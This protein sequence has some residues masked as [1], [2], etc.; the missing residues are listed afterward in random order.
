MVTT[1]PLSL[2]TTDRLRDASFSSYLNSPEKSIM[3]KLAEDPNSLFLGRK[4][5][6]EGEI[7]VFG[8]EKYFNGLMGEENQ[9][10]SNNVRTKTQH[11]KNAPIDIS[12]S[13]PKIQPRT[14]SVHSESSWNSQSGL[15]QS[16][17]RNPS[18]RKGKKRNGK[19]FI[20]ILGCSCS[21]NGKNSVVI[22]E[23]GEETNSK[24]SLSCGGFQ[25]KMG[26]QERTKTGSDPVDLARIKQ[27]GLNP[28]VMEEIHC[29]K[30]DEMGNGLSRED[31]FSFP[32]LNSTPG[33]NPNPMNFQENQ[34]GKRWHNS[35]EV[36]G[37]SVLD[38]RNKNFL[39]LEGNPIMWG[40]ETDSRAEEFEIP[41]SSDAMYNDN[42]SD[43]S[44][45]LFEIESFANSGN[46]F[47]ERNGSDEM[48]SN[49]TH[50]TCYAPSEVSIEWSV[51]TASAAGFSS[52]IS[53]SEEFVSNSKGVTNPRKMGPDGKFSVG[54]KEMEKRPGNL[55]G[56]KSNEAVRV[57]GDAYMRN[58]K[59]NL[60][61]RRRYRSS[62]EGKGK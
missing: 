26:K 53:D 2:D 36:F 48:S 57:A 7:G 19:N 51:V 6:E 21:C 17:K 55:L 22:D 3:R 39:V 45:D 31:C 4:K 25:G 5:V 43:A 37:S 33:G 40:W 38:K 41:R 30:I 56:C 16:V 58:K 50:T 62:R 52:V 23:K 12:H 18:Q 29:K 20:S 60:D 61:S 47:L 8:A 49:V 9:R 32:I 1:Q 14:P 42:E 27:S 13:K 10:V 46:S 44:S 15:L 11:Q 59:G 54:G 35:L 34:D 28:W 24:K